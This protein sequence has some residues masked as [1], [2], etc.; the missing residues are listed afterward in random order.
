MHRPGNSGLSENCAVNCHGCINYSTPRVP[1]YEQFP[2]LFCYVY[3]YTFFFNFYIACVHSDTSP[4]MPGIYSSSICRHLLWLICQGFARAV[5]AQDLLELYM[6]GI[7][8]SCIYARDLHRLY[9]RRILQHFL[10]LYMS[11]ICRI[12]SE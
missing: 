12:C 11:G 6:L 1:I 4:Y 9:M 10:G 2:S 3:S 7:Y 8:S 5:Y